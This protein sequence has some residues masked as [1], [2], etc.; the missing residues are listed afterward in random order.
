MPEAEK[1]RRLVRELFQF[2]D[3]AKLD[4]GIYRILARVRGEL[5][6]FL[7]ELVE[8]VPA[9]LR[10]V[11]SDERARFDEELEAYERDRR[12]DF[13]SVEQLRASKGY[14]ERLAKVEAAVDVRELAREVFRDLYVFFNRYWDDGDFIAAP[15]YSKDQYAIPYDGAEVALHWANKDQYYVKSSLFFSDMSV[16]LGDGRLKVVLAAAVADRDNTKAADG[17]SRRF[18]LADGED[19]VKVEGND[20][21]VHLKYGPVEA[22]ASGE[23][24]S[25]DATES[26]EAGTEAADEGGT[27]EAEAGGKKS[28]TPKQEKI[29]AETAAE[30][31]KRAPADWKRWLASSDGDGQSEM[32]RRLRRYTKGNSA[33][34]FIHKNLRKFLRRELDF[35][36]KNEVFDLDNIDRADLAT[37]DAK[38]KR[39]KALRALAHDLIDWLHQV[40]EF[41]RRLF[42]KKKFVLRTDWAVT[43]DR[44]P[45]EL[46]AEIGACD[47]QVTRWRDMFEISD[48]ASDMYGPGGNERAVDVSFLA[49]APYLPVETALLPSELR[50]RVVQ[51]L[52]AVVPTGQL[53]YGDNA[54]ALRLLEAT[55]REEIDA[56]FIDPP[57]NT[58]VDGFVYKDCYQHSTWMTMMANRLG[59]CAPQLR[60]TAFFAATLDFVES[61]NTRLLLDS[62]FG[63]QQ[64][65]A[66]VAWEKRYTRSNN[67]SKFY[68]LKDDLFIYA[69]SSAVQRVKEART[70]GSKENYTNPDNDKRGP[71]ISSS[72]V[73]PATKAER[74]QLVYRIW[75]PIRKVWVEHPTHSWK[76]E[77]A[78]Y[79][80]HVREERLYW[81]ANG[82]YE[83]PRLKS[84]L[85]DAKDEMVP[86]DV[87]S[88]QEL[89]SYQDVGSTDEAGKI[90]K[91]MFGREV[92]DNPKPPGLV[93]AF[94]NL[95]ANKVSV[96]SV[97]DYF[98]GS[99][100]TGHAVLNLNRDDGGDRRFILIEMGE[101]FDTVLV[102]R[103]LK[104][105]YSKE[106]KDGR[107]VDRKGVSA[108]YKIIRLESY[109]DA[110]ENIELRRPDER[111]LQLGGPI[112]KDYLLRYMLNMEAKKSM[113]DLDRFKTPFDYKIR[114]LVTH[115]EES[116][117][118]WSNVEETPVDLVETFNYLL[119]LRVKTMQ[120]LG[121]G[122]DMRVARYVEG[123]RRDTQGGWT[124][125]VLVVWRDAA[126]VDD[127]KLDEMFDTAQFTEK[128]DD[129]S[130][131]IADFDEVYVNG[132][133]RL[134][135]LRRDGERW[136]V[137]LIETAFHALMFDIPDEE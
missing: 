132:D 53:I 136:K 20:L 111:Q 16:R 137:T 71:W 45:R 77:P 25:G 11:G 91:S 23:S 127:A 48:M 110:L 35:F 83:L 34:F 21:V 104:A 15:R 105:T 67:A 63:R 122:G 30:I 75:N 74:P 36:I 128:R 119:G 135:N 37:L 57:Y 19:A 121:R 68:S 41:Q 49:R 13:D 76:Y 131:Y 59:F 32:Y 120:P 117:R 109:D 6:A 102:P 50:S 129:G 58:G 134:P 29:D 116:G 79:E 70:E 14:K 4:F 28:K 114:A 112:R 61:G 26:D 22:A 33:D 94:I 66:A 27:G 95:R 62:F 42:L 99:G 55:E 51:A 106:W 130:R 78:T 12:D 115:R 108:L 93:A 86:V 40:E 9:K 54:H 96:R 18:T 100:T 8:G 47:E 107:P 38:L 126:K 92:F 125:K 113:L 52:T 123:L 3:A 56:V 98:A 43:L 1:L 60:D 90:L 97:L 89:W 73:N 72:Y 2:D 87:W 84:F 133:N 64:F 65:L 24:E 81:G 46:W 44:V 101:H 7:G 10:E 39:V 5:D 17:K 103:I 124:I 85:R 31:I 118:S 82:D 69:A 88:H 80:M